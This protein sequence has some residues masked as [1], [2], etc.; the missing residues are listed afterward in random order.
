MK[1]ETKKGIK[2]FYWF[3]IHSLAVV[4]ILGLIRYLVHGTFF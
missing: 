3:I 1:K 4:G 2:N